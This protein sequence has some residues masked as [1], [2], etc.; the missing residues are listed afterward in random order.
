MT[1]QPWRSLCAPTSDNGGWCEGA[2]RY[3]DL[4]YN[5]Y[6]AYSMVSAHPS[7]YIDSHT[8]LGVGNRVFATLLGEVGASPFA[9][10]TFPDIDIER[11]L[12]TTTNALGPSTDFASYGMDLHRAA[13]SFTTMAPM[14][15]LESSVRTA[16]D[17]GDVF[18]MDVGLQ[19]RPTPTGTPALI[20]PTPTA[21][22]AV[23]SL[24]LADT[25]TGALDAI[26]RTFVFYR[27]GS[28]LQYV[29][30]NEPAG[31]S[32]AALTDGWLGPCTMTGAV[33]S[34][35]P[36]A[37]SSD[38]GI[39]VAWGDPTGVPVGQSRLRG[40]RLPADVSVTP[41]TT[42]AIGF[43]ANDPAVAHVMTGSPSIAV[44]GNRTLL[45]CN[46]L[47]SVPGIVYPFRTVGAMGITIGNCVEISERYPTFPESAIPPGLGSSLWGLIG[48]F[49]DT[50]A[51]RGIPQPDDPWAPRLPVHDE[52][53]W[54]DV[55][56]MPILRGNLT[57]QQQLQALPAPYGQR[58]GDAFTR[59]G[60]NRGTS[61]TAIFPHDV[62]GSSGGLPA[63]T[64]QTLALRIEDH[65]LVVAFRDVT[66]NARTTMWTNTAA[67][68]ALVSV[69]SDPLTDPVL[70]TASVRVGTPSG[71]RVTTDLLYALYGT[72][73][74]TFRYPRMSY[75]GASTIDP[76]VGITTSTFGAPL[77]LDT[78]NATIGE[79]R[80]RDYRF[81]R[82]ADAPVV[83]GSLDRLHVFTT[84]LAGLGEVP[85][86]NVKDPRL[87][88]D[89]RIRYTVLD[90][91]ATGI[92]RARSERPVRLTRTRVGTS[93]TARTAQAGAL[94]ARGQRGRMRWFYPTA[95]QLSI[96]SESME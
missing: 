8:N 76:L 50:A 83:A 25:G 14:S 89:E 71:H 88:R 16:L 79:R 73:E 33:I 68:S 32:A 81:L 20:T 23:A 55:P 74:T 27:T 93:T 82:T 87:D 12:V 10:S 75:R 70:T 59:F 45:D 77:R 52:G 41:A 90:V 84:E 19:A 43:I 63:G 96:R 53:Q 44:W 72:P 6:D 36:S 60:Q 2:Q 35:S 58:F 4:G 5:K 38:E 48:P 62:T 24:L 3:T 67:T 49:L 1:L 46:L 31:G 78:E 9:V 13:A 7:N 85:V 65:V 47:S 18:S 17:N 95:M 40:A 28:A 54:A 11:L 80:K 69:D 66:N 91:L 15:P 26:E 37:A 42:C 30:R 34:G 29:Y 57:A 92:L 86:D 22:P 51:A 21:R 64:I 94:Q 39:F 61:V 56:L